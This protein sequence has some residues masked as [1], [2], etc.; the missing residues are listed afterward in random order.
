MIRGLI[1]VGTA[2][3]VAGASVLWWLLFAIPSPEFA[4]TPGQVMTAAAD[5]P[6]R[7]WPLVAGLALAAGAA[8]IGVGMNRWYQYRPRTIQR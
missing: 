5:P 3:V 1:V 6:S 7:L 2:L 8:C 4:G